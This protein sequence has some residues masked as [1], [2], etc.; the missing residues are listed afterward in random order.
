MAQPKQQRI[1]PKTVP[2]PRNGSAK[3]AGKGRS[4]RP[5]GRPP[6]AP[7]VRKARL[8]DWIA[9]ARPQTLALSI[10]PV[11]LGTAVAYLLTHF[12]GG[13]GWHWLRALACL[14]VAVCL[15]IGVNFANDYSDG[16]R[17]TD[18]HRVGPARLTGSGMARP[19]TVLAV[20][21]VFFALAA[22][23]GII[24]V[25]RTGYWWLLAVGAVALLAA[26]F[27]TG[28]KRPYGYAGLGELVA[29]LFFGLVATVGTTY[30]LSGELPLDS[31]ITGAAVGFLAAAT[32][33][34][35]NLRDR[36]QDILAGKRTLAVLIGDRAS[37]ILFAV[38]VLLPFGVLVY[39][40]LLFEYAGY[41]FF[42]LL[43]AVPAA[44]ITILAKTPAE[45][46]IALRLTV[47]T[48]LAYGLGLGAAIAF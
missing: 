31:W 9:G 35:N 42:A 12:E 26:W 27:Y 46:I 15:Q 8:G 36:E 32:L 6:G 38:L 24:I 14:A 17:G 13:P 10:A 48:S 41:V 29:F 1:D 45:L 22:A 19:R 37:R 11:A 44:V 30:V 5:G 20:A 7:K 21:L 16:V 28:G 33:L 47:L 18:K 40:T 4:G 25:V 43:A 3:N 2:A 39:Y 23:A 34:V